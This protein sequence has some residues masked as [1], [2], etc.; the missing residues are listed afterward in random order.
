VPAE[1]KPA[2]QAIAPAPNKVAATVADRRGFMI[3]ISKRLRLSPAA[4]S[5]M[6]R[7]DFPDHDVTMQWRKL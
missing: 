2:N 5:S 6:L 4:Q 7:V 3:L 1:A